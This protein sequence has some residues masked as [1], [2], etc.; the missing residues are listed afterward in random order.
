MS[1]WVGSNPTRNG[2]ESI[3]LIRVGTSRRYNW[4]HALVVCVALIGEV[5]LFSVEILHHHNAAEAVCRL[6]HERGSTL[7]TGQNSSAACPLCQI[8]RNSSV[9]PAVQSTLQSPN[10]TSSHRATLPPASYASRLVQ[11]SL[12]RSPPL[13]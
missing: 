4:L 9:R 13:F 5:H 11:A 7:H 1:N 8:V 2:L 3:N 6:A 12:A 10:G